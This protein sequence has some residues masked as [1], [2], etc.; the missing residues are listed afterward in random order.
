MVAAMRFAIVIGAGLALAGCTKA[1]T[2]DHDK[3]PAPVPSPAPTT[4]TTPT[5]APTTPTP[6]P[7]TFAVALGDATVYQLVDRKLK[8]LDPPAKDLVMHANGTVDV[9][10]DKTGE[11]MMTFVVDTDGTVSVGGKP[12]AKLAEHDITDLTS[13]QPFPVTLDGDTASVDID[14]TTV[15]VVLAADGNI[16]VVDRPDGNKWRIDAKDP[17]VMRTAFRVLAMHMKTALD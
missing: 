12:V 13:N 16:T 2:P 15:K 5:P 14:G 7:T 6:A 4:P 10:N 11:S 17:A 1:A 3:Q 9:I 8:K